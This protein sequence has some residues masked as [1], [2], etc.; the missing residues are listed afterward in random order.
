MKKIAVALTILLAIHAHIYAQGV[1]ITFQEA[2]KKGLTITHLDSIYK[3]AVISDTSKC[4]FK[5]EKEQEALM[6]A[7]SKLLQD[8][9]KFL[10]ANNFIWEKPTKCFQKIYFNPSGGV[11]YFLYNFLG[12]N[13]D[14]PSE[15]KQK[16]FEKIL[17]LFIKDYKFPMTAKVKF[18]QCSSSKYLPQ[19]QQQ[20]PK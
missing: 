5:T 17:N 3:S 4:V 11:D 16:E 1:A 18:A 9:G 12:T 8:L 20:Q 14:R 7:Y 10:T 6:D 2:Y 15:E 19:K 13:E